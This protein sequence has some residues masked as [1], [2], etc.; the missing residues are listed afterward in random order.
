MSHYIIITSALIPSSTAPPVS[1]L[2][3][4]SF[5]LSNNPRV[6]GWD[7]LLGKTTVARQLVVPPIGKRESVYSI[8]S[9][10]IIINNCIIFCAIPG[11]DQKSITSLVPP[12]CITRDGVIVIVIVIV[13]VRKIT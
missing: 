8:Y 9:N 5:N 6:F 11:F 13:I 7:E 4:K 1:V 3:I 12:K 2:P 10:I